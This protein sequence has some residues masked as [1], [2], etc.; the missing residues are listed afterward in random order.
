MGGCEIPHDSKGFEQMKK[1][2]RTL[3]A[4]IIAIGVLA[5]AVFTTAM[6]AAAEDGNHDGNAEKYTLRYQFH[7]GET[8]RWNV[9]H[10]TNVRT[11]VSGTSKTV[12]TLSNSVKVWRV[13]DVQPDG[14]AT[15]E[16]SVAWADMR[17]KHTDYDEIHY[18]SRTDAKPPEAFEDVAK[19]VGVPLTT[20][21]MDTQGKI[22]KREHREA[23]SVAPNEGCMTIPL[24][25]EAVPVGYTWSCPQDIDVPLETGGVKKLKAIQRFTLEDIKTGVATIRVATEII[26]LVNNP[27][28]ESKLVQRESAGRVRFDIDAGRI[29]GQQ[30]DIDKRV[31]GFRGDASSI[32]YINRFCEQIIPQET[33]TTD[34]LG[35]QK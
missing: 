15:F 22:L 21:T 33:T 9:E 34:K 4:T 12:E 25:E 28:I 16:H 10:R 17:Q 23:K 18:D 30:M 26:S 20:I 31:V 14:A 5:A 29:I 1:S 2:L 35:M 19:S 24:P 32:H 27:A 6:P 7:A 8:L 13:T 11:T 3:A